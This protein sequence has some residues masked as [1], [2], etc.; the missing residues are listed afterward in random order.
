MNLY[1]LTLIVKEYKGDEYDAMHGIVV[2]ADS[3]KEAR[4][5]ANKS[6]S[7]ETRFDLET[8]MSY[9]W[10]KGDHPEHN[11]IWLKPRYTKIKKIG[12]TVKGIK[13]GWILVDEHWG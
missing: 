13:K 8:G 1:K 10:I 11:N 2:A 9:I 6:K 4:E 3:T 12:V 7:D 5:I